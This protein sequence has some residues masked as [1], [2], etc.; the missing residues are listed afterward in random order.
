MEM[1]REARQKLDAIPAQVRDRQSRALTDMITSTEMYQDAQYILTYLSS[2]NE[3]DTWELVRRS[4]KDGKKVYA[5][6]ILSEETM[7]FYEVDDI[8]HLKKNK[9]GIYEPDESP[10]ALFPYQ[11]HISLDRAQQCIMF[12]PGLALTESCEGWEEAEGIMTG[13]CGGFARRCPSV[14]PSMSR[15]FRRVSHAD[16]RDETLDLIVTEQG[17]YF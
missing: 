17:A 2:G 8:D 11:I 13:T 6:K 9:M 14:L 3:V 4:L 1:R 5:P 10:A 15:W 12:V 7:E 16:S